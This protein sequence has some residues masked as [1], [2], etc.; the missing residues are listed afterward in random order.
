M[1]SC[2]LLGCSH[3]DIKL[4]SYNACL[5]CLCKSVFLCRL[6]GGF[7]EIAQSTVIPNHP[8]SIS[9]QDQVQEQVG[10][11]IKKLVGDEAGDGMLHWRLE[12]QV[13]M[14]WITPAEP[15]FEGL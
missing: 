5:V 7:F 2:A 1:A 10:S 4:A 3:N 6:L 12:V 15:F 9:D 8:N 11:Y 13:V 14:Q